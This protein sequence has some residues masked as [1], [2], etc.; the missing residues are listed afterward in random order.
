MGFMDMLIGAIVPYDCLGCGTEGR[1]LCAACVANL[2]PA[3]PCCYR[4]RIPASRFL[5]CMDCR[6]ATSLRRVMAATTYEQLAKR[7]V[8]KLKFGHAQRAAK[9]IAALMSPLVDG[10]N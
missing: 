9:E 3:P 8:W 7:L 2:G 5:V 1:L 6:A 4:C 10:H